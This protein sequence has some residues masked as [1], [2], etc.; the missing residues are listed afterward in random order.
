M[1]FNNCL[2]ISI[3]RFKISRWKKISRFIFEIRYLEIYIR[4]LK[5][6]ETYPRFNV[7]RFFFHLKI[8]NLEIFLSSREETRICNLEIAK[9]NLEINFEIRVAKIDFSRIFSNLEIRN[10][11]IFLISREET[12]IC[13]L[14]MRNFEIINLAIK[15]LGLSRYLIQHLEISNL[16]MKK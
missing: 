16:E 8:Q 3:S 10:L 12:R 9:F 6:R 13:N 15:K 4:D 14:E 2:V 11:E 7:S 1:F 5:S